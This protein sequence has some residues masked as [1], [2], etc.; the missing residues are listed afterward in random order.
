MTPEQGSEFFLKAH[1][2]VVPILVSYIALHISRFDALTE[3]SA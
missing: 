3:K 1:L 2:A